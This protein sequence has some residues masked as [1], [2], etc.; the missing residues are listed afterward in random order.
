MTWIRIRFL[1]F[2]R[3]NEDLYVPA[4][5]ESLLRT[6]F[7]GWPCTVHCT[8]RYRYISTA[9]ASHFLCRIVLLIFV[10]V[11]VAG[12][13]RSRKPLRPW[14]GVPASDLSPTR[15]SPWALPPFT[16]ASNCSETEQKGTFV[17]TFI[18]G[19]FIN[20]VPVLYLSYFYV[21][22]KF[23]DLPWRPSQCGLSPP[24]QPNILWWGIFIIYIY[25][26]NICS[27]ILC[28]VSVPAFSTSCHSWNSS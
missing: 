7:G 27:P 17:T 19:K 2:K 20:I 5:M 9:P 4:P 14:S 8:G 21:F 23:A 25:Q 13:S 15:I 12:S 18:L 24:R 22:L 11:V 6:L 28:F 3:Q 1:R 16:P 26:L 10:P